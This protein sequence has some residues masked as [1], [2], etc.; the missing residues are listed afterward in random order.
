[1]TPYGLA[2]L[3]FMLGCG[4]GARMERLDLSNCVQLG[5]AGCQA[6]AGL[7]PRTPQLAS[8]LLDDVGASAVGLVALL[9][10]V[11]TWAAHKRIVGPHAHH[12][13]TQFACTYASQVAALQ[14]HVSLGRASGKP[15]FGRQKT[16]RTATH[17]FRGRG[18]KWGTLKIS[19]AFSV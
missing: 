16:Y 12:T 11:R 6:V 19:R 17:S 13:H 10:K 14:M 9:E 3:C 5:D 1:M 4:P 2:P 8:L 18:L 7:L 15:C